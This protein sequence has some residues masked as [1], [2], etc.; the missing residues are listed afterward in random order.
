MRFNTA[1]VS[2]WLERHR[3]PS[4]KVGSHG[5]AWHGRTVAEKGQASHARREGLIQSSH[6]LPVQLE[7]LAVRSIEYGRKI[8]GRGVRESREHPLGEIALTCL[9]RAL[10]FLLSYEKI[11]PCHWNSRQQ[12]G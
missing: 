7:A 5:A 6:P 8:R 9:A 1:Q 12:Q 11:R 2:E 3:V 4:R 10:A